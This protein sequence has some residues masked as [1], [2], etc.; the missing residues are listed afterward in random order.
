MSEYGF[1]RTELR[2]SITFPD[3]M[4]LDPQP[5]SIR[6]R[7]LPGEGPSRQEFKRLQ[8]IVVEQTLLDRDA[9]FA[10][11]TLRLPTL[12][13]LDRITIKPTIGCWE[14]PIYEDPKNIAR[15][16]SMSIKDLGPNTLAHRTMYLVLFGSIPE[17]NFLDH[18]CQNKACCWGR[19]L[20]SVLPADNSR[21]TYL[22]HQQL[23][24][25]SFE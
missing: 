14:L 18:L 17:G 23:S 8:E 5:I 9:L 15:Y 4:S 3:G 19:H 12:K 24:F 2:S 11:H 7:L 13:Q 21:R 16:A 6:G 20:E 22:P 25:E 1:P 10:I